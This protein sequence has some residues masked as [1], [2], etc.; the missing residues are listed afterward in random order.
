VHAVPRIGIDGMDVSSSAVRRLIMEGDAREAARLLG[1]RF[2]VRG[3]VVLG[4]QLGREIG[5]PTA[6]VAPPPEIVPLRDGI[7]AS[8]AIIGD[9]TTLRPA[10]TYIGT[11][12]AVNTG[13]RMIETHLFDFD[14]DLYGQ[15]LTT[16]FV[17]RLRADAN[18][19]SL[20]ALQ[21]QLADDERM[22][23]RV[24]M[25]VAAEAAESR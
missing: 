1:H 24:L 3:E 9:S 16:R 13:A 18:F 23:R 12:P 22:A 11:R 7:Y 17:E 20:A 8:L 14:G 10:M 21:A 19:P 6:N 2:E 5:F 15:H 25:Q 4:N